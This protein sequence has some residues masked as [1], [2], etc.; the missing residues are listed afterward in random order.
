MTRKLTGDQVTAIRE[1]WA[2]G[3]TVTA[4]A[5]EY[6]VSRA[7]VSMTA[8]GVRWRGHGGPVV[9]TPEAAAVAR[10]RAV[11][12]SGRALSQRQSH[13]AALRIR[14]LRKDLGWTQ[15]ELARKAGIRQAMLSRAEGGIVRMSLRTVTALASALGADLDELLAECGHCHGQP[16]AGYRCLACGN[17]RAL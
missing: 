12:A 9:R 13:A 1:R 14:K 16:P 17:E 8:S 2:Q 7:T 10:D 5:A 15:G 4:L 11:A 3:E 6:G